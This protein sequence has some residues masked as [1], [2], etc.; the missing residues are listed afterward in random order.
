MRRDSRILH[1]H[2][3]VGILFAG[4]LALGD[5]GIRFYVSVL[6]VSAPH[7]VVAGVTEPMTTKLIPA[8]TVIYLHQHEE[9]TLDFDFLQ[10]HPVW[11]S[12]LGGL[13][14]GIFERVLYIIQK[15]AVI[16]PTFVLAPGMHVLNAVLIAGFIFTTEESSRKISFW[17]KLS[18]LVVISMAIHVF[19][20]TWGVVLVYRAFH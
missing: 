2:I 12:V 5:Y 9:Y 14:L 15:D 11:L 17:G 16:S 18:I 1:T 4:S 19:W 8:L 13:S 20:N 6:E 10:A 7:R 3:L